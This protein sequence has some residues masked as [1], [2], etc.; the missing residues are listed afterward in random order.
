MDHSVGNSIPPSYPNEVVVKIFSSGGYSSGFSPINP[1]SSVLDVGCGFGNNLVYFLDKYFDAGMFCFFPVKSILESEGAGRDDKFIG[2][3]LPKYKA[4]DI[5]E[6]E[7]WL[8]A[9]A[10]FMGLD[11]ARIKE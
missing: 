4:V 5:D 9:E 6:P 8:L 10:I 1:G 3:I 7:D 2:Q 11:R